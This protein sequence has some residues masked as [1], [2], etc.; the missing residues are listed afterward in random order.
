MT[1][2]F[3]MVPMYQSKSIKESNDHMLLQEIELGGK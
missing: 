2:M 3:M 1:L